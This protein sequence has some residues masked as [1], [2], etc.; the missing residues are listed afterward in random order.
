MRISLACG[1]FVSLTFALT[2]IGWYNAKQIVENVRP[3]TAEIIPG[4]MAIDPIDA[5]SEGLQRITV[6]YIYA[7]PDQMA[8]YEKEVK[9]RTNEILEGRQQLEKS[10]VTDRGHQLVARLNP[11]VDRFVGLMNQ[12]LTLCRT[13]QKQE[14]ATLYKAEGRQSMEDLDKIL[15]EAGDLLRSEA[16]RATDIATSSSKSTS[17]WAWLILAFSIAGGG[18]VAALTIRGIAR[19]LGGM[20]QELSGAAERVS[21]AASQVA[22]SSQSL[23]QGSSEQAASL[24][25]TSASSE[26]INAMAHKNSENSREIACL[27]TGSQQKFIETNQSLEK[28]VMAMEG[29]HS[30][31]GKISK[32]IK[33]IDEIAFQTNIL[34]L[35]AAV[36][37][38]RAGEAGMGFAVVADEVRSGP[39]QRTGGQ[40][41]CGINRGVN[42]QIHRRQGE[43]GSGG[44]SHSPDH[45]RVSQNQDLDG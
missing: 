42:L 38:A 28:T 5:G 18:T 23:A 11:A 12:C 25:E 30:H 14:A 43:G 31:S 3:I 44:S 27:V 45:R 2:G 17:T 15:G 26:R 35:N 10:F 20:M 29:I 8:E 9:E 37:A 13:N 21:G 16:Q 24:E 32:I 34:A 39:T 1:T 33:V 36:E 41:Y 19:A 22:S 6:E 40:G 4:V 7:S